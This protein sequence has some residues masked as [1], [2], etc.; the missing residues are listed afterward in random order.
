LTIF[1]APQQDAKDV[2]R[3]AA[4]MASSPPKVNMLEGIVPPV[5]MPFVGR[6]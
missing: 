2:A 6:G 5:G 4:L 1:F 3:V